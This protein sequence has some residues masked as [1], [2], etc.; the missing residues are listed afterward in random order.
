MR[1]ILLLMGLLLSCLF[2]ANS[3]AQETTPTATTVTINA[4][5][6][7]F[8]YTEPATLTSEITSTITVPITLTSYAST[9]T[10]SN[11]AS[12]SVAYITKITVSEV[13][14]TYDKKFYTYATLQV[15]LKVSEE[16]T[17]ILYGRNNYL[18]ANVNDI[19]LIYPD[20]LFLQYPPE[21]H[22]YFHFRDNDLLRSILPIVTMVDY[23]GHSIIGFSYNIV[24]FYGHLLK[25]FGGGHD[26]NDNGFDG[27][28]FLYAPLHP[29]NY[30]WY[31]P[32][33]GQDFYV[34]DDG[35]YYWNGTEWRGY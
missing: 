17:L 1:N 18:G 26:G 11:S 2:T 3:Y 15:A 10:M 27:G 8:Y 16:T 23:D 12:V 34:L 28:R 33:Q 9:V 32:S 31:K 13:I 21:N 5:N 25:D 7:Y 29:S 4:G 24:E 20:G 22:F 19:E 6:K 14:T 30:P 35:K